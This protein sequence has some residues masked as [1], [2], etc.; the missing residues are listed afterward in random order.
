MSQSPLYSLF[1]Q[2]SFEGSYT[3]CHAGLRVWEIPADCVLLSPLQR[4]VVLCR[5]VEFTATQS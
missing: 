5:A 2:T 1:D 3:L 4:L